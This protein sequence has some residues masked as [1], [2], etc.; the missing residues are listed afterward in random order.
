M[1][2]LVTG[3]GGQLATAWTRAAKSSWTVLGRT[4]AELD[5]GDLAAV[6]RAVKA[7]RPDLI[8]NAAAFTAVDRAQSQADDA[9]RTNRD[10]PRN[11][12]MAAAE[13]GA[14]LVHIS[15]DFV[16]D[17]RSGRPYAPGDPTAPLGV[18]G[19]SKLGGEE[20][21]RSILA[22]ALM[23][24]TAWLYSAQGP[25]FL[26]TILGALSAGRDVRVVADQIGTPTSAPTLAAGLWDLIAVG[27]EGLHHYTD[28]GA[29]SWY[30]FAQAIGEEA[31]AAGLAPAD[32]RVT[33]ISSADYPT[34]APR[35]PFSV[36][37]KTATW[38][39]LGAAAPHWRVALRRVLATMA[40]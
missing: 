6:R 11:L 4:R 16:F 20:A 17:G 15:T 29:A 19:A 38:A 31:G 1:R 28:A 23:V 21:V 8:L 24:R 40:G 25:N 26:T 34:A 39:L 30:D 22:D 14:R 7:A 35:P 2:A 12:A 33:P 5:I 13:A 18:Y 36:L 32:A 27:A 37:D 3:A 9:W 10:G